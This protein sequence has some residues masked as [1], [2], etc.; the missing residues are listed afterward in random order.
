M[1]S[2]VGVTWA[3]AAVVVVLLLG[4]LA[5]RSVREWRERRWIERKARLLPAVRELLL[6]DTITTDD[7]LALWRRSGDPEVVAALLL[8]EVRALGPGHRAVV[9]AAF[10]ATGRVRRDL[11]ALGSRRWWVRAAAAERLGRLGVAR[12]A[13]RLVACLDDPREEVRIVAARGLGMLGDTRVIRPLLLGLTAASRWATIRAAAVLASL[14]PPAA[15]TLAALVVEEAARPDSGDPVR[16]RLLLDS[17]AELGG[18]DCAG[19]VKPLLG[20]RSVD[21]RARAARILG[22]L[23]APEAVPLLRLALDDPDWPV[24]AQA[25]AA[26]LELPADA[27]TL[28]A[29][30][31]RLSDPAFWVRANA[32]QTLAYRAEPAARARLVAALRSADPFARQAAARV[33]EES[34]AAEAAARALSAGRGAP[35]EAAALLEGLAAAGRG[36]YLTDLVRRLNLDVDLLRRYQE[37]RGGGAEP[38]LTARGPHGRPPRGAALRRGPAQSDS[39]GWST[40]A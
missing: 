4:V 26:L 15:P 33:L 38:G 19:A 14:G 35:A 1:V 31:A 12:A 18:R 30:A 32:A 2:L 40:T 22:R 21:V 13:D 8:D 7:V 3:L 20:H 25:A 16:L 36:L 23:G 28:D 6:A 37:P 11:E 34:G 39:V 9:A 24:R 17:L 27:A 29:L 10:E 5:I